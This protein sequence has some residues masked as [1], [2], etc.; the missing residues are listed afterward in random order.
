[1]KKANYRL[2][3][4]WDHKIQK[5][6][7]H[8]RGEDVDYSR[9]VNN[10]ADIGFETQKGCPNR[11]SYCIESKTGHWLKSIPNI[12]TEIK[13]LVEQGYSQFNLCDSEFN[14]APKHA[15]EVCQ[16][17][18]KEGLNNKM[19]WYAY[20]TP[21]QF[22]EEL[23]SLMK[24]AGC[25]GID[26]GVDSGDEGILRNLK[27]NFQVRDVEK[28][29]NICKSLNITFMYDLL[30]GGPGETKASVKNTISLMKEIHPNRVGL[31]IGVRIYAGTELSK[32]ILEQGPIHQNNN[33][34]GRL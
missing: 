7:V 6:L 31:S 5:E 21:K 32:I 22:S 29:A 25:I 33:I 26:F 11:C 17:L 13:H 15:K 30:I 34:F 28:T 24:E 16:A 27:R 3:N 18:I 19:K 23:G 2:L 1:M 12:I 10:G 8:K 20:C 4:G 14:I 9:Y